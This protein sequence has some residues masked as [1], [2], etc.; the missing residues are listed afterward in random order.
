MVSPIPVHTPQ[1]R[2]H[3]L[4]H[5]C[6]MFQTLWRQRQTELLCLTPIHPLENT[7]RS[8][9]TSH[10][11]THTQ[12]SSFIHR[13]FVF[14]EVS[15]PKCS[16]YE[17]SKLE[18]HCVARFVH[19]PFNDRWASKGLCKKDGHKQFGKLLFIKNKY[20]FHLN[21]ISAVSSSFG[22]TWTGRTEE[23]TDFWEDVLWSIYDNI[24]LLEFLN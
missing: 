22:K 20:F 3:Q 11:C 13:N 24:N 21:W 10:M 12:L 16:K 14:T 2:P 23:I 5:L 18:P 6:F 7:G 1:E 4:K 15:K 17:Y 19:L 9:L 8:Y